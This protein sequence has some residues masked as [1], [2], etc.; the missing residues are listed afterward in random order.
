MS[1]G[2]TT[3]HSRRLNRRALTLLGV[4]GLLVASAVF[5]LKKY[6]DAAGAGAY[7]AEARR[8]LDEKQTGLALGYLKR[9]LEVHPDDPEALRLKAGLLADTAATYP[10]AVDAVR[11]LSRVVELTPKGPDRTATRKRLVKLILDRQLSPYF[12]TAEQQC[13]ALVEDN[14]ADDAESRQLW[15]RA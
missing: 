4:A 11:L 10:Q 9:Y 5:G 1:K 14:G 8:R 15:G 2:R 13:R 6:R 3:R 12:G 7:L